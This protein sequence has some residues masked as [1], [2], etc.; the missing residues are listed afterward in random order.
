MTS[1]AVPNIEISQAF[2]I[3]PIVRETNFA[4]NY[5]Y[6]TDTFIRHKGYV[7]M[8]LRRGNLQCWWIKD[9]NT[10]QYVSEEVA[11][12][13]IDKMIDNGFKVEVWAWGTVQG[14]SFVA[15]LM[16]QIE[17]TRIGKK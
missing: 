6:P 12:A 4:G 9:I 2:G 8:Q 5:T 3:P 13:A 1:P 10:G 7:K 16:F 15:P 11:L 14:I 17:A